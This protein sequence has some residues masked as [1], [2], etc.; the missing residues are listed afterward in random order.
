MKDD[1][2]RSETGQPALSPNT[3]VRALLIFTILCGGCS[4]QEPTEP[5]TPPETLSPETL[6]EIFGDDTDFSALLLDEPFPPPPQIPPTPPQPRPALPETGPL[7]V[8]DIKIL[9]GKLDTKDVHKNFRRRQRA[10]LTCYA[11]TL[12]DNPK[13]QGKVVVQLTLDERGRVTE[14]L[15]TENAIGDTLSGCLLS[16]LKRFRFSLDPNPTG[17]IEVHLELSPQ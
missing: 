2:T 10:L 4:R 11:L 3:F 7:L 14:A 1:E 16:R 13:G 15:I 5:V 12:V 8:S 17:K 6:S 9:E